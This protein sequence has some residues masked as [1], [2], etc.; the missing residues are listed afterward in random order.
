MADSFSENPIPEMAAELWLKSYSLDFETLSERTGISADTLRERYGS[1]TGL[2]RSYYLEAFERYSILE[3]ASED[4]PNYTLSE[5][6][7]TMAFSLSEEMRFVPRFP[8]ETFTKLVL[9]APRND[10]FKKAVNK[11]ISEFL[12]LEYNLSILLQ[13]VPNSVLV[14]SLGQLMLFLIHQRILDETETREHSEALIDK[15][16]TL[17]ESTLTKGSVDQAIDLIRYLVR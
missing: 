11:R 16:T 7:A 1:T 6:L 15:T 2:L 13:A 5:K 14:E 12:K 9:K 8:I 3:M 17:V 4:F 10:A